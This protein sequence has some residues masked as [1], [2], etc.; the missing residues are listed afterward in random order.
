MKWWYRSIKWDGNCSICL[1][2]HTK[3]F[4]R[5]RRRAFYDHFRIFIKRV[6]VGQRI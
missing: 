5:K 6:R 2:H 3:I 4:P 1:G